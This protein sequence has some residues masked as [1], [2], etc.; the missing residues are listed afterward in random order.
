MRHLLTIT[1]LSLPE[2]ETILRR[3][4]DM[5]LGP[6]RYIRAL[7]EQVL[8]MIFEAPSLRTRLSFETA[9]TQ[10]HGHAINYY[11]IHSPWGAGKESIEDVART[12]SRYCNAV[13]V[14]MFSHEELTK[15]AVHAEVPVIN[16]MTNVGHPCQILGDFLT[17]K[18]RFG[19]ETGLTI[20]YV[21][22][23]KNNVTYSLMRAA[24]MTGNQL[25]IGCPASE[26]YSPDPAV[27]DEL[28]SIEGSGSV[29]V[30]PDPAAAV[31]D[32]HVVY[33]DSWMS[34]RVAD[35][36]KERRLGDLGPYRV[37]ES[38]MALAREDAVFMH[39]LPAW[40]GH[41]V[42]EGVIDGRQSIVFDQ[43]ENRL[44]TEKAILFELLGGGEASLPE[45]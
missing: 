44:H 22:D 36:E 28:A 38:L 8:L 16:A 13:S 25:R 33:T 20:A 10:L 12:L 27:T 1:D 7:Y 23:A 40:R 19:R 31:R 30:T 9:M 3:A 11:T 41:E 29:S 18:E 34:Y 43:A 6:D 15:L 39:C 45:S 26:D 37:T 17:M 4:T 42:T 21:G 14:R 35:E 5:K 32:A 24:V 2:F